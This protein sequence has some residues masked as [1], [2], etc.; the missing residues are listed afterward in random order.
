VINSVPALCRMLS[1]SLQNDVLPHLG[2]QFARGQLFAVV[3]VLNNLERQADW[4]S[5]QLA[6]DIEQIEGAVHAAK[7]ALVDSGITAA[8]LPPCT[9]LDGA[10]LNERSDAANL[11]M[12][13]LFDWFADQADSSA[14]QAQRKQIESALLERAAAVVDGQRRRVAASMMKEMSGEVDQQR[15][16]QGAS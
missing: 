1:K 14:G 11:E 7:R 16:Q 12:C 4:S 9:P 6:G 10:T 2:D 8:E 5:A 3:Y 15:R 13:G